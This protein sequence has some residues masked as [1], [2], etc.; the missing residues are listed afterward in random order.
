MQWAF[1]KTPE[2]TIVVEADRIASMKERLDALSWDRVAKIGKILQAGASEEERETLARELVTISQTNT[3]LLDKLGVTPET[4]SGVVMPSGIEML[5]EDVSQDH[6]PAS[7]LDAATAGNAFSRGNADPSG[8]LQGSLPQAASGAA[9]SPSGIA[10][11][12]AG[13]PAAGQPYQG[14]APSTGLSLDQYR[15]LLESGRGLASLGYGPAGPPSDGSGPLAGVSGLSQ[16]ASGNTGGFPPLTTAEGAPALEV[17]G[18]SHSIIH[19]VAEVAPLIPEFTDEDMAAFF[20]APDPDGSSFIPRGDVTHP[21]SGSPNT[22]TH[23]PV[24]GTSNPPNAPAYPQANVET[25][26]SVPAKGPQAAAAEADIKGRAVF[27]LVF[28]A[29]AGAGAQGASASKGQPKATEAPHRPIAAVSADPSGQAFASGNTSP[30]L[31]QDMYASMSPAERQLFQEYLLKLGGNGQAFPLPDNGGQGQPSSASPGVGTAA[32]RTSPT[33]QGGQQA[34][35]RADLSP[36]AQSIFND[37]AS[38]ASSK[39]QVLDAKVVE[40]SPSAPAKGGPSEAK[41][42]SVLSEER[43]RAYLGRGDGKGAQAKGA[44][45]AN[46]P[47]KHLSDEAKQLYTSKNGS[48]RLYTDESGHI[49]AVDTSKIEP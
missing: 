45:S 11:P 22:V 12:T 14:G 4:L 25:P 23:L 46:E 42:P 6:G 3:S 17:S 20:L 10:G 5:N 32:Q 9:A 39:S 8:P 38:N 34:K 37:I 44:P 7:L 2:Q 21:V 41:A 13:M 15:A 1:R 19:P 29:D 48:L 36:L 24:P 31:P 33:D 16:A 35:A 26:P 28:G 43:L 18:A 30:Y 40:N 47:A 49:V 27:E